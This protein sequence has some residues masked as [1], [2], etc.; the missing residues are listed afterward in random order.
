MDKAKQTN[1]EIKSLILDC[2]IDWM[3]SNPDQ[4]NVFLKYIVEQ[5]HHWQILQQNS[6]LVETV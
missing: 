2:V 5:L 3:K 4:E 6:K 1:T